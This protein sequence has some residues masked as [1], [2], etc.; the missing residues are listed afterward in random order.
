MFTGWWA[1]H[2]SE[3]GGW[4]AVHDDPPGLPEDLVGRVIVVE[5]GPPGKY[6]PMLD[7]TKVVEV[8]ERTADRVVVREEKPPWCKPWPVID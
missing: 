4:T 8:L 2:F 7:F 3:Y 6:G 5:L 1:A